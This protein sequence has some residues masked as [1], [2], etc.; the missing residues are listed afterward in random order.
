[1][2]TNYNLNNTKT[3]TKQKIDW[4]GRVL[5][6][7]HK[8]WVKNGFSPTLKEIADE[9][10]ITKTWVGMVLAR[11]QIKGK[12]VKLPSKFRNIRVLSL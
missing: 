8:F 4:E 10:G 3:M 6:T 11:L 5:R 12:V 1:M 9:L 7:V 2:A